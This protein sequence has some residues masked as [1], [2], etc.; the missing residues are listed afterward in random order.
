MLRIKLSNEVSHAKKFKLPIVALESTIITHG[1][2]Y[3][4]NTETA[5]KVQHEIRQSNAVP[6]T[7]AVLDGDLCVGLEDHQ[8]SDLGSRSFVSKLSRSD[9]AVCMAEKGTGSTTVA[10]TMIAAYLNE[11]EV[12]ATGGIGGAHMKAETTFDISADLTELSKTPVN[13]V[14]AGPKAILDIPKTLEILETLGVPVIT[15]G[16]N[17]LPAFWS[18]SSNLKSPIRMDTIHEIAH[19]FLQRRILGIPGGQL[20]CN[21]IEKIDEIPQTSISKIVTRAIKSADD[22]K[23]NGK[24]L[25]PFLLKEIFELTAGKSLKANVALILNNARLAS[26]LSVKLKELKAS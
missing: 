24:D 2:P 21:P 4:E 11:I 8:I 12:F 5:L 6:A 20:I 7:I 23:V 18:S 14:C 13:V 16:Q 15:Y 3:P 26:Q 1:M 25:T 9:L 17:N 10:A 19:A 22:K